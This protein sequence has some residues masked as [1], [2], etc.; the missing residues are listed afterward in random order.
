MK[1]QATNKYKS[2]LEEALDKLQIREYNVQSWY[3]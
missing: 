2:D 1:E 3:T